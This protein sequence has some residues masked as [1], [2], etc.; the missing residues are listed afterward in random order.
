MPSSLSYVMPG[1]PS[2]A[3]LTEDDVGVLGDRGQLGVTCPGRA[4]DHCRRPAWTAHGPGRPRRPRPRRC[5]RRRRRV[6]PAGAGLHA[7][8]QA[9]EE[10]VGEIG[11]DQADV[12]GPAGDQTAGG[13]VGQVAELLD[14]GGHPGPGR[15]VD[16]LRHRERPG[17]GGRRHTREPRHIPDR[18]RHG[19]LLRSTTPGAVRRPRTLRVRRRRLFSH[20]RA[21]RGAGAPRQSAI[22][23]SVVSSSH[24]A[25]SAAC[26]I[27]LVDKHLC[28]H[29][30]TAILCRVRCSPL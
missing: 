13:A 12:A 25:C 5:P 18:H 4:E 22:G 24:A 28:G 21:K 23:C 17:H 14:R 9:G 8:G 2:A 6:G 7:L 27:R 26:P 1:M 15:G 30:S 3:R 19:H 16:H 29:E 11:H 10:R 20:L